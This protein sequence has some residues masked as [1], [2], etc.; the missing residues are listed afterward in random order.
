MAPKYIVHTAI[1]C[2]TRTNR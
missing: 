2:P 1:S